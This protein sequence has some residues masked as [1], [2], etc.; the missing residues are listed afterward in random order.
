MK[1]LWKEEKELTGSKRK[2]ETQEYQITQTEV[3]YVYL[4]CFIFFKTII[5]KKLLRYKI[6]K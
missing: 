4:L 5:I 1:K 3:K 2:S 6:K